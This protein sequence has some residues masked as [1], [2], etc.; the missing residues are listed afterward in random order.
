MLANATM[1]WLNE[2][3]PASGAGPLRAACLRVEES[4]WCTVWTDPGDYPS[5]A[6]G[7]PL[8][9]SVTRDYRPDELAA[10]VRRMLDDL[11]FTE[12]TAAADDQR[13]MEAAMGPRENPAHP[14]FRDHNC[15]KCDSG[16]KP[17]AKGNPSG[18]EFPRARND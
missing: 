7:S 9:D 6:G 4:E 3:R 14:M 8:P 10:E 17:C 12:P 1:R 13:R 15:W 5:G 11:G 16:A 2:G 18:C